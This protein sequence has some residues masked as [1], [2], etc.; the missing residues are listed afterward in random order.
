VVY[1]DGGIRS[2]DREADVRVSQS[3]GF[4]TTTVALSRDQCRFAVD[5][6]TAALED[7][8]PVVAGRSCSKISHEGSQPVSK[9]DELPDRALFIATDQWRV[10]SDP[11]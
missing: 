2:S 7:H 3:I 5:A 8:R 9:D 11:I 4:Q 6:L 1:G 10:V